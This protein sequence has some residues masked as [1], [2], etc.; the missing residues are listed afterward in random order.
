[1]IEGDLT[2]IRRCVDFTGYGRSVLPI[3]LLAAYV[4]RA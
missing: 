1:M 4:T 3:C 2:T